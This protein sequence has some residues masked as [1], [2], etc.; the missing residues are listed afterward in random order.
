MNWQNLVI[1]GTIAAGTQFVG[2]PF[3]QSLTPG[4]QAIIRAGMGAL[5]AIKAFT[6][7]PRSNIDIPTVVIPSV[8]TVVSEPKTNNQPKGTE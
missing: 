6:S 7:Q 8:T 1:Y 2:E 4:Q 3:F 5:V